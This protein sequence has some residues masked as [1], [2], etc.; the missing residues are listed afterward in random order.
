[1]TL[2]HGIL[3]IGSVRMVNARIKFPKGAFYE[4][5]DG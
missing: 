5:V 3:W 4:D 2:N 1:M